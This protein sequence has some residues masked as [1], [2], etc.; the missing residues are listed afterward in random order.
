MR[1]Y[2]S[3]DWNRAYF[4]QRCDAPLKFTTI[5]TH[6]SA[7]FI[8][9]PCCS[10]EAMDKFGKLFNEWRKRAFGADKKP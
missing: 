8:F 3:G 4:A 10:G 1:V 6:G 5:M 7:S 2:K 9:P